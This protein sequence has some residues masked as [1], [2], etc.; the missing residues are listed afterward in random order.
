[1]P[2]SPSQVYKLCIFVQPRVTSSHLGSNILQH[3]VL[4][5]P[6]ST[7]FPKG[8]TLVSLPSIEQVKL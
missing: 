8:G 6:Q 5:H 4:K 3:P 7:F 2:I 1:M